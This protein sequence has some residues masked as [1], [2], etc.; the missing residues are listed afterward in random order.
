MHVDDLTLCSPSGLRAEFHR[1][2]TLRTL[3]CGELMLNL[4]PGNA[5]E[6]GPANLVLRRLG[7]GDRALALQPLLGP[8]APVC[9]AVAEGEYRAH[10]AWGRL[11]YT[12][13]LRLAA[14]EAAWFWHLQLHNGGDAEVRV[15]AVW[16][17][18]LALA[19]RGMVRLNEYYVSHYLDH[20]PLAH[21]ERGMLLA[22]RQ[23]L[24]IDG[25]HPWL[26]TGSL[27]RA[28]AWATDAQQLRGEAL[29]APLPST[30]LQHEHAMAALQDAPLTLAAGASATLGFFGGLRADH[31][32]A[33]T[34]GDAAWADAL[35][36]LPEAQPPRGDD[37]ALASPPPWCSLFTTAPALHGE[38]LDDATLTAQFGAARRQVE[39]GPDGRLWAFFGAGD[40]HV[41][42]RAKA[43][44]TARPHGHLLRSGDH[45]VPD[46]AA[47]TSTVWMDGAFHSMVTQGH[48]SLNRFLSAVRGLLGQFHSQGQRVF[49]E[50]GR[51]WH[52]LGRPSAFAMTADSARWLYRHAGGLIEVRAGVAGGPH[53]LTL[54]VR[55]IDGAPCRLLVT[56]HVALNGDDG[57]SP[58]TLRWVRHGDDAVWIAADPGS[59]VARRFPQGGFTLRWAGAG[60]ERLGGDEMLWDDGAA[61][62]ISRGLPMV[63]LCSEPTHALH[64]R[65]EADLVAEQPVAAPRLGTLQVPRLAAPGGEAAAEDIDALDAILPWFQHNALVH[66][67]APRGLEQ[68]SG[69]GWGTRDVCQGPVDMLLALGC[70]APV[71]D[72][73]RRVFAAQNADGDWPQWFMFF[74]RDSAVRAGD[75]HGDI[76]FW[77][78]LALGQYLLATGDAGLLDEPL[79]FFDD[80]ASTAPTRVTEHV[81]RA[82]AVIRRR[83]VAGTALAAYGHG[84]WND[85]LQPADPGLRDHLCSAWTV[86]LHHQVLATLAEALRGLG[87][88]SDAWGGL[89]DQEAAAVR[90]DFQRLLM[91][92]GVVAGYALF[93][94]GH[95]APEPLIHPRDGR[96]GLRYSLLPMAHAVINGLFNAEQARTH[97]ALIGE[98][99]SG[100]DGARLFDRP[101]AYRGGPTTLFQRAESASFFGREIGLM[102]THAHLR[103]AEALAQ[104]GQADAFFRALC[105]ANPVGLVR[106]V[107]QATP[108]QS[109]C[110]HS[111]SDAA[112]ADRAEASAR[113][114]ALRRG[115]VPLDGGWRVYSSGAGI[116]LGLVLRSFLG[117][118]QDAWGLVVDPVIP[119]RLDGLR[120]DWVI[121]GRPVQ[122]HYRVGP[123]G[124]GVQSVHLNGQPLAFQREAN[125]YRL[126]AARLGWA[127]LAG[128]A[129]SDEP[130]RL[131]IV[132]G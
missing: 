8:E 18:D 99:L 95:D 89:L 27:R 31:P 64:L 123:A 58:G 108:R 124:C 92:D 91:P 74:E 61:D 49:V 67:L 118:R 22:T 12:L 29:W 98:H 126:G 48:V 88:R 34:A 17:Q 44:A 40:A 86:T 45:L 132:L 81:R 43:E 93:E 19:P 52:R 15:D 62:D 127:E 107:P 83:R 100:P 77:P 25:C 129:V 105:Q 112:F 85:S 28:V 69:G 37:A 121:R 114:D 101:L 5:L 73:L 115:E 55:V 66:Y 125:P 53:A 50:I 16:L 54:A 104:H 10:G 3:S 6:P 46:E 51:A 130:D 94:P 68:F 13:T 113:Y 116:G 120:A 35:L 75:S 20:Q 84:D 24:P 1:N 63:C 41:V 82:F 32:G 36:A 42:L 47:L 14:T 4:F 106:R 103:Y 11:R 111:S 7:A 9:G 70:T 71:R 128:S 79:A 57:E 33:T 90:A 122:V 119:P 21:A 117:L 110:Y 23:N 102:Y 26:L 131:E 109:N 30:R 2:G 72:L 78:L 59:D 80:D 97:L 96:T 56:H 39:H 87:R 60:L 76:V 38:P 65:I